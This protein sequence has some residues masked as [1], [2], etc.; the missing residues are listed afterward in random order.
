MCLCPKDYPG[1]AIFEKPQAPEQLWKQL[2]SLFCKGNVHLHFIKETS[3]SEGSPSALAGAPTESHE[4][5][6]YVVLFLG[7]WKLASLP[8]ISA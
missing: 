4:N 8:T 7:P 5:L 3:A 2:R 6:T 1:L